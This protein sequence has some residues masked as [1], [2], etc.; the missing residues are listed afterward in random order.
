MNNVSTVIKFAGVA[1]VV[2]AMVI[3]FER[4]NHYKKLAED[5]EAMSDYS[6]Q[7][8]TTLSNINNAL[9][10]QQKVAQT[11]NAA[12]IKKLSTELFALKKKDEKKVTSVQALITATQQVRIHDT[13]VLYSDSVTGNRDSLVRARDV[14]IPPRPFSTK[15][16][17]YRIDGKVLL[18]GVQI[19]SATIYNDVSFRIG[20][21]HKNIFSSELTVQAINSNPQVKFTGMHSI[22]LK[23]KVSAWHRWILPGLTAVASSLITYKIV[24]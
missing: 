19:D 2:I 8:V 10:T 18:K 24:K 13:L 17:F 5:Y 3:A 22:V 15:S 11:N 1:A 7:Q 20:E 9:V 4:C 6:H 21:L 16:Q 12:D 23:A 14:I